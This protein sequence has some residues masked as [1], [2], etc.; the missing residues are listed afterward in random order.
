MNSRDLICK[1]VELLIKDLLL[2]LSLADRACG[3]TP[4]CQ[5]A[6]MDLLKKIQSALIEQ[7]TIE[8]L[9]LGRGLDHWGVEG[10]ELFE[11]ACKLSNHLRELN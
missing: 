4:E 5:S 1:E 10:G 9:N 6:T 3:W 11:K 7:R 8:Q 2:P